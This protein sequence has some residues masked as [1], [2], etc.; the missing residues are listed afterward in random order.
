VQFQY[1]TNTGSQSLAASVVGE[2]GSLGSETAT[3]NYSSLQTFS[4]DFV[5]DGDLDTLEFYDLPANNS[6]GEDGVLDNVSISPVSVP[7]PSSILIL[8]LGALGL[9]LGAARNRT[10]RS[11][12]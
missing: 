2:A 1:T 9:T 7:E 4:F 12:L 5:G 6:S 3:G 10:R 11:E 8:A